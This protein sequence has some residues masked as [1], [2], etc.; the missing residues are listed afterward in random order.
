M[1]GATHI[2]SGSG[3]GGAEGRLIRGANERAGSSISSEAGL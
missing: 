1:L 3:G 2:S